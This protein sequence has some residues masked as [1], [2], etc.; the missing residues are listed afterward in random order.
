[1][2]TRA[3]QPGA[4]AGILL[5]MGLIC[6][7]AFCSLALALLGGRA[8]KQIQTGVDETFGTAVA[9][10][11]LRNKL[12]QNND[13]G[14]ISLRQEGAF[15]LLVISQQG[16]DAEYETRIYVIDG[17]L[18]ETF[19]PKD[20]AFEAASGLTIAQVE[21]CTFELADGLFTANITGPGGDEARVVFALAGAGG[22]GGAG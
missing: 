12:T 19:V 13:A 14:A 11:Y 15:D 17:T 4:V 6:L 16:A 3:R 22:E 2:R 1:M 8:Y 7:F 21:S 10:S 9:G 18:R 20:A 5:P